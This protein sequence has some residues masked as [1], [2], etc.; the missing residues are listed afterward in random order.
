MRGP[1]I[2]T[3]KDPLLLADDRYKIERQVEAVII[4]AIRHLEQA[5][6]QPSGRIEFAPASE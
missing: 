2:E 1:L 6:A 3:T 5:L 4:R